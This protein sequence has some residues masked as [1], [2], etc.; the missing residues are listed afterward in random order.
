M[1]K[2]IKKTIECMKSLDTLKA[3]LDDKSY[4]INKAKEEAGFEPTEDSWISVEILH[5]KI[6]IAVY[7]GK[8]GNCKNSC[9]WINGKWFNTPFPEKIPYLW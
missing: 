7:Q 5:Y 8:S 1:E 3:K 6:E 2:I 4:W 9:Y